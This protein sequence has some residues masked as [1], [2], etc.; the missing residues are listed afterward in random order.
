MDELIVSL[1]MMVAVLLAACVY[2]WFTLN[3][4]VGPLARRGKNRRYKTQFSIADLLC[5]FVLAQL[6]LALPTSLLVHKRVDFL[7]AL[8]AFVIP[9]I[10]V[11][12][13]WWSGV[14][15]LSRAEIRTPTARVLTLLVVLPLGYASALAMPVIA[16][17]AIAWFLSPSV[18]SQGPLVGELMLLAD[19]V[20]I[21][22]VVGLG[23]VTRRIV[24]AADRKKE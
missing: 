18:T 6:A 15:L 22:I 14:D 24:A 1:A 17:L 4:M 19:A 16:V 13:V 5:L 3:W 20:L 9:L 10:I 2:V 7:I 12:V 23:F 11:L 21:L 8:P